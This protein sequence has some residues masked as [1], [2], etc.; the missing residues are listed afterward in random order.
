M[1]LEILL[2][3]TGLAYVVLPTS[4]CYWEMETFTY[5]VDKYNI[6]GV[7]WRCFIF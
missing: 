7:K 3:V 5:I 2:V 6:S 1:Y 4:K